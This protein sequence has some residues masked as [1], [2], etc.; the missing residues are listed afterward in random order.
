MV[1][2]NKRVESKST[3]FTMPNYGDSFEGI[4]GVDLIAIERERKVPVIIE[5]V[6]VMVRAG[7]MGA[8]RYYYRHLRLR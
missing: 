7:I 1:N 3:I 5:V 4:A 8:K 2:D 6:E